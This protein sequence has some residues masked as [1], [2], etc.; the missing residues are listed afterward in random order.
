VARRGT[1]APVLAPATLVRLRAALE[2]GAAPGAAL[3]L[4]VQDGPLARS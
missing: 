1:A 4:A 2:A 3:L